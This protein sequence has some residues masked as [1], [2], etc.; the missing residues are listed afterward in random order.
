MFTHLV[1]MKKS[2]FYIYSSNEKDALDAAEKVG[3][4]LI[5]IVQTDGKHLIVKVPRKAMTFDQKETKQIEC[6]DFMLE[7]S[8]FLNSQELLEQ[9]LEKLNESI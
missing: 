7:E 2:P 5:G 8:K 4:L 6:E 1:L 9:E 3:E